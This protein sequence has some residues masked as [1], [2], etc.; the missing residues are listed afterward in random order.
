[1]AKNLDLINLGNNIKKYRL[2]KGYTQES[3]AEKIDKTANYLSLVEN[4]HKGI[5]IRTLFDIARELDVPAY[6]LLEPCEK[7]DGKM[8]K[9]HSMKH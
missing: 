6:K 1:M 2:L 9:R 4:G 5:L 7:I 3:F 8:K